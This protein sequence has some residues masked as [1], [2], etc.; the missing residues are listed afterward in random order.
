MV[1][2]EVIN[3]F[4]ENNLFK[5]KTKI[6]YIYFKGKLYLFEGTAHKFFMALRGDFWRLVDKYDLE[7]FKEQ[8]KENFLRIEENDFYKSYNLLKDLIYKKGLNFGNRKTYKEIIPQETGVKFI[9]EKPLFHVEQQKRNIYKERC[10][11]GIMEI[12]EIQK[13]DLIIHQHHELSLREVEGIGLILHCLDCK[14]DLVNFE[15][16]ENE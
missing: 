15:V 10:I 11:R 13:Q 4:K 1:S 3:T 5:V 12:T 16:N 14:M 7:L 8:D 2:V 6:S 9:D